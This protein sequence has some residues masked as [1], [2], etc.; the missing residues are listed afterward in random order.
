MGVC[1][2]HCYHWTIRGHNLNG[3]RITDGC[4]LYLFT[5]LQKCR[6]ICKFRHEV[7]SVIYFGAFKEC[8]GKLKFSSGALFVVVPNGCGVLYDELN[9]I[10]EWGWVM[11]LPHLKVDERLRFHKGWSSKLW[12]YFVDSASLCQAVEWGKSTGWCMIGDW[13]NR[14]IGDWVWSNIVYAW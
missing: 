6:G 7:I 8:G 4:S 13:C 10:A 12:R 3:N 5:V 14:P 9:N 11:L 1:C 2:S